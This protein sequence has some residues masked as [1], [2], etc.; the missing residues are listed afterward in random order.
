MS[1]RWSVA[2]KTFKDCTDVSIGKSSYGC[3]D[4]DT[5]ITFFPSFRFCFLPPPFVVTVTV[6]VVVV[7]V[8]MVKFFFIVVVV[9][10]VGPSLV[11]ISCYCS[12][13]LFLGC[14]IS[15]LSLLAE[16]KDYFFSLR[17]TSGE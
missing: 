14:V 16:Q 12:C 11:V 9:V 8:V 4:D 2:V 6:V 1:R 13:W 5:D 17:R 15:I 10:V 3:H 7:V